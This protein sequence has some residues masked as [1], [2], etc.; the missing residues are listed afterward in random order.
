MRK[1]PILL[2]G[3]MISTLAIGV[4]TASYADSAAAIKAPANKASDGPARI[5]DKD[6][7]RLSADGVSA[8]NDIHMARRAIFDGQTDEAATLVA[9]AKTSLARAKTDD[10]ILMKAE[11]ALRGRG[12]IM[13]KTPIAPGK[14]PVVPIAWIPVDSEIA[15]GETFVSTPEN[16][17]AVV[18]A[19]KGIEKGESSKS[20]S[21]IKMA[22]ID[23]NYTVAVA[24][25][26]QSIADIDQANS[27]IAS[28]DYYGASQ[29]L[30]QAEDGIRYDEVDD[31]ANVRGEASA[32]T[33]M[34]K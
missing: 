2:S 14:A 33:A 31:V 10:A 1:S 9:D 3:L 15:L 20:L 11:S 5:A 16:A 29:A 32:S 23:V 27:L 22:Q 13:P 24:P 4:S 8:F 19:R 30:R 7:G 6:F 17:A 21:A 12:Q 26:E 28:H 34:A 18:T 25:L